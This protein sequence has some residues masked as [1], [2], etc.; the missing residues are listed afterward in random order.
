MLKKLLSSLLV[1]AFAVC[2]CGCDLKRPQSDESEKDSRKYL[3]LDTVIDITIYGEHDD[4]FDTME[5]A[6]DDY[7]ARLS[8][9]EETS[10]IA[11]LNKSGGEYKKVSTDIYNIINSAKRVHD[12]TDGAF[13]ISVYPL[14]K[15]WGFTTDEYKIPDME[16][17]ERLKRNVNSNNIMLDPDT[18]SVRLMTG[19][20]IDLGGIAKGYISSK[21]IS[22]MEKSGVESAIVSLGG[23]VQVL[24]TKPDGS[25]WRVGIQ[26]PD[27]SDCYI[28]VLSLIN[29]AAITSGGY[30]RYF[31]QDGKTYHHIIDPAT[32]APA[33]TDIV[34]V[35]VVTDKPIDGDGLSTAFFVMGTEK[36][37]KFLDENPEYKAVI[38]TK[39]YDLLVSKELKNSFEVSDIM[40]DANIVYF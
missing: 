24:G 8:V 15:A 35:T 30:Q 7:E 39:N 22:S 28:G 16:E 21:M 17:I 27:Y 19:M 13:D 26:H 32:G 11:M 31:V 29:E 10:E 9:T 33:E 12:M 4:V 14:V 34:S 20:Q 36:T 6:L 3:A 25:A 38:L 2:F 1:V 40:S 37:L 5:E 23:N 18:L